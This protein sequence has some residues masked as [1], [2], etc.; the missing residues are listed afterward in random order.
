MARSI[1]QVY[2]TTQSSVAHI[3]QNV[4]CVPFKS[5]KN[6]MTGLATLKRGSIV[7][8][9]RAAKAVNGNYSKLN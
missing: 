8:V 4:F 9:Q 7:Q 3:K 2:P 5:G 6:M 1:L